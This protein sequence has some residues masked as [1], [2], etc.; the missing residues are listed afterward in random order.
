MSKRATKARP[1][2][3]PK[4]VKLTD[5][6]AREFARLVQQ[7]QAVK[8]QV[9]NASCGL[10][11][12]RDLAQ[13]FSEVT[14]LPLITGDDYPETPELERLLPMR[15]MR[16]AHLVPLFGEDQHL[17]LAMADPSDSFSRDAAAMALGQPL[18]LRVGLPTEI[19]AAVRA[20]SEP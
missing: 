14:G 20:T 1:K 2:P 5:D 9:E 7:Q 16:E 12:E 19:D 8:L 10:V 4:S 18:A 15:F 13:A 11:S 6:E 17:V 3:P